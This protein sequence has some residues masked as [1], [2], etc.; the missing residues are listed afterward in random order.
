MKLT[1]YCLK[2]NSPACRGG[3]CELHPV[4]YW[5]RKT[6]RHEKNYSSIELE[7]LGVIAALKQ[8]RPY[9]EGNGNTKVVTDNSAVCSL[10]KRRDAE[11]RLAK[12]QL[13]IQAFDVE[14]V[15]RAGKQ[16]YLC[17]YMSRYP[18][19]DASVNAVELRS[20]KV[21]PSQL[22]LD[23][24][25]RVQREDYNKIFEAISND[26]WPSSP[27]EKQ[28]LQD[29]V[30]DLV[31][32][33]RALYNYD[34]EIGTLRLVIPYRLRKAVLEEFHADTL[35]S[36][37][38]GADK[39]LE[40][41]E[42]RVFWPSM[43]ADV[44]D[45]VVSCEKCQKAKVNPGD[46]RE[47]P[48]HLWPAV[49]GPMERIHLDILG[50]VP[51]KPGG[52]ANILVAE[53]AF[54]KWLVATPLD[55]TK[56]FEVADTFIREVVTKHGAP[57]MIVTDNGRQFTSRIFKEMARVCGTDLNTVSP[58]HQAAN[59]AVER[60]NRTI[61]AM[62]RTTTEEAGLDW[63][64]LLHQVVFAYNTAVHSATGQTPFFLMHGRDPRLP[65]DNRLNL[66]EEQRQPKDVIGYA[67]DLLNNL[68][69]ARTLVAEELQSKAALQKEFTD[70]SRKLEEHPFRKGS[71]VL[72]WNE[73]PRKWDPR[74]TGPFRI[75]DIARPRAT[76]QDLGKL[77]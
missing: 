39:T 56:A 26:K 59:G 25:R 38:L 13:A 19:P 71:L 3:R 31:V 53:D 5:S 48:L 60:Q 22:A 20:G 2:E 7:A 29:T 18:P 76:I 50:P 67:E 62:I 28:T 57:R 14:F 10:I 55:T 66:P 65:V 8:F 23:T 4:V 75:I 35:I 73:T 30:A 16:N 11:G 1:L 63:P 69:K 15:H 42:R 45:F 58:Y 68:Q 33:N 12:F 52:P 77:V 72:K 41:M 46:R 24:V 21:V 34:D 6:N 74:W 27:L 40:K 17:D 49:N 37:H 54:S 44:R 51:S 43:K 64:E 47:E 70:K 32:K 36:A 61:A 9:I